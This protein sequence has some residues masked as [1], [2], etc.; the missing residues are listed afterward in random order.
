MLW[1]S[2]LGPYVCA[3]SSGTDVANGT[4]KKPLTSESIQCSVFNVQRQNR[5]SM[6][7]MGLA[8]NDF[9]ALKQYQRLKDRQTDRQ[10]DD[11]QYSTSCYVN[12][13]Q[14]CTRLQKSIMVDCCYIKNSTIAPLHF[15]TSSSSLACKQLI[16]GFPE[17]L[18]GD[19]YDEMKFHRPPF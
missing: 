3:S 7:G 12:V 16:S 9:V 2:Q 15:D 14:K 5:H 10:A 19:K 6:N 4:K 13:L 11:S 1:W 17:V 18:L 8:Q